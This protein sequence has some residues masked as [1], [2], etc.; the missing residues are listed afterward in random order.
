MRFLYFHCSQPRWLTAVNLWMHRFHIPAVMHNKAHLPP[1][2]NTLDFNFIIKLSS[3]IWAKEY[4]NFWIF[5]GH[6]TLLNQSDCA[7]GQKH[8]ISNAHNFGIFKDI[9]LKSWIW[10][11]HSRMYSLSTFRAIPISYSDPIELP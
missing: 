4:D 7:K 10:V 6:V 3:D 1:L 11:L 5:R 2:S 8:G 9:E